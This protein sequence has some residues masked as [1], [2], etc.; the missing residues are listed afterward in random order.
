MTGLY[1]DYICSIGNVNLHI[2]ILAKRW[3]CAFNI[4]SSCEIDHM[5]ISLVTLVDG[6]TIKTPLAIGEIA[7]RFDDKMISDKTDSNCD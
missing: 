5:Y 6:V 4:N 2:K 3:L 1:W 7:T